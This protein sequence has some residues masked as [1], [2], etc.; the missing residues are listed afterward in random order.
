M[1]AD[2]FN[3]HARQATTPFHHLSS[4]MLQHLFSKVPARQEGLYTANLTTAP[5]HSGPSG[6]Y[7][8]DKC[9]HPTR[10]S[11]RGF[12]CSLVLSRRLREPEDLKLQR[13]LLPQV[14]CFLECS[15]FSNLFHAAPRQVPAVLHSLSQSWVLQA[16]YSSTRR[17]QEACKHSQRPKLK[18]AKLWVQQKSAHR[19]NLVYLPCHFTED[20]QLGAHLLLI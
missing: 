6:A 5:V 14:C 15:I 16:A 12:W 19:H 2:K 11:R 4:L 3:G 1:G 13:K 10:Q 8:H 18:L 17:R 20:L 7:G 9:P